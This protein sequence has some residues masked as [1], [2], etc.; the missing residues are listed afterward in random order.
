MRADKLILRRDLQRA[1]GICGGSILGWVVVAGLGLGV[2]GQ[3]SD[4][5]LAQD[6]PTPRAVATLRVINDRANLRLTNRTT[7]PVSYQAI[8]DTQVRTLAVN[9]TVTLRS[10]RV[11]VNLSFQF[12]NR[13]ETRGE[14][15]FV[16]ASLR[17]NNS[18]GLLEV[19]LTETGN[20][21]AGHSFVAIEPDG[22]IYLY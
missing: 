19:T 3:Q 7:E 17:P 8:G 20:S 9:Q 5:L 18:A 4:V 1:A 6:A 15:N 14:F 12:Q 11:P 10:L 21:V 22:K 16:R 13:G 2:L